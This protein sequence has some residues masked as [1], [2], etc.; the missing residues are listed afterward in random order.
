MNNIPLIIHVTGNAVAVT[1]P[2]LM[3]TSL[4][5]HTV[6]FSGGDEIVTT[7]RIYVYTHYDWSKERQ[8]LI[9]LKMTIMYIKLSFKNKLTYYHL[10][11]RHCV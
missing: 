2:Q 1:Y 9:K 7:E 6:V 4:P 10:K 11:T 3:V 8:S 5:L